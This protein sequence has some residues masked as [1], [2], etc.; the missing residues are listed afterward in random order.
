MGTV[1]CP[2][3]MDAGPTTAAAHC[4]QQFAVFIVPDAHGTHRVSRIRERHRK[5][6]PKARNRVSAVIHGTTRVITQTAV[7]EKSK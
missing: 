2:D 4:G 7:D 6:T 5:D 1:A 3:R